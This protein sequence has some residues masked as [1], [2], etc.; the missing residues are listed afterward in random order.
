MITE[1]RA[2]LAERCEALEK[3]NVATKARVKVLEADALRHR[4]QLKTLI[5]KTDSDDQLVAALRQEV[6]RLRAYGKK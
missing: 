2:R 6:E 4:E 5:E 1:D 3:K